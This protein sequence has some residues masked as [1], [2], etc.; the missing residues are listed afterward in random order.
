LVED[1]A[2]VLEAGAQEGSDGG[3][4]GDTASTDSAVREEA[5]DEVRRADTKSCDIKSAFMITNH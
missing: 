1:G 5:S 2:I 3:L 4:V